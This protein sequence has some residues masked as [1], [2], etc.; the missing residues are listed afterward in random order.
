MFIVA[1]WRCLFTGVCGAFRVMF[2]G[3]F[4]G[5]GRRDVRS[6]S[7]RLLSNLKKKIARGLDIADKVEDEMIPDWLSPRE[8]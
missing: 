7:A 2:P 5:A 1:V 8:A 6:C 3:R 4:A